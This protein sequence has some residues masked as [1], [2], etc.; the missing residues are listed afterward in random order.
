MAPTRGGSNKGFVSL[1]ISLAMT[2][3]SSE[4]FS[5]SKLCSSCPW[6]VS[7]RDLSRGMAP[8]LGPATRIAASCRW[9]SQTQTILIFQSGDIDA[10]KADI[11]FLAS[12]G[13]QPFHS[14]AWLDFPVFN[15]KSCI[16]SLVKSWDKSIAEKL[17]DSLHWARP[18]WEC[19]EEIKRSPK[20][21]L[22][23]RGRASTTGNVSASL[24]SEVM[25][26]AMAISPPLLMSTQGFT[27]GFSDTTSCFWAFGSRYSAA[28]SS[29]VTAS[30]A[31]PDL[32]SEAAAWNLI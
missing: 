9:R 10:I 3:F 5:T 30:L 15:I 16:F 13:P 17:R 7:K 26:P 18:Q 6:L 11:V 1:P 25:S 4:M 24:T 12:H 14:R 21:A 31:C 29:F 19:Q 2:L 22:C 28:W 32:L 27:E 8:W 23:R 20:E